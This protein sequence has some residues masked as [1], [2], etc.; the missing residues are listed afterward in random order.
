MT[1]VTPSFSIFHCNHF[2]YLLLVLGFFC[3]T[4]INSNYMVIT[5]TFI[6]MGSENS[7]EANMSSITNNV[8]CFGHFFQ[9]SINTVDYTSAEKD[10]IIWSLSIGTLL[11]TFPLNFFYTKYGARS[12]RIIHH[13]SILN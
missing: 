7:R 4:S 1:K 5:F 9:S 6:C 8:S 13:K 3:L 11:G 12:D 2:R 10:A